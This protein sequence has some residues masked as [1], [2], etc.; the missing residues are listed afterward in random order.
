MFIIQVS[1]SDNILSS[2]HIY[3][4]VSKLVILSLSS[5]KRPNLELNIIGYNN[6]GCKAYFY[7]IIFYFNLIMNT[8]KIKPFSSVCQISF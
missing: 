7:Q 6:E 8:H 5:F 2:V 1:I 3:I 4:P